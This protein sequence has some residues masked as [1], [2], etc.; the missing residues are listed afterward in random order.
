MLITRLDQLPIGQNIPDIFIDLA[1]KIAIVFLNIFPNN[2]AENADIKTILLGF[3]MLTNKDNFID[4]VSLINRSL[5]LPGCSY[6]KIHTS[7]W[8]I[9]PH[10]E[11]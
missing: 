4:V 7:I 9:V 2:S 1:R 6:K 10:L 3:N 8:Y 11:L 5:Q